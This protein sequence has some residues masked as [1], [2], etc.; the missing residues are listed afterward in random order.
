MDINSPISITGRMVVIDM[1]GKVLYSQHV[2]LNPGKQK[3]EVSTKDLPVGMYQLRIENGRSMVGQY[4]F[5]K[6]TK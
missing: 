1:Q 4:R 2:T 3:L 5:T 6:L